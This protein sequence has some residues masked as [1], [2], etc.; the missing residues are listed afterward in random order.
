MDRHFVSAR[1]STMKRSAL[2][3][4]LFLLV[5][6]LTLSAQTKLPPKPVDYGQWESLASVGANGGF[7][8]DGRWLVYGINRSNRNNEI[9]LVKPA[10]GTV[11]TVAFGTQPVF[12][13]DS[14]WLACSVGMSEADSKK[15]RDDK[16]PVQNKL[17]LVDLA[18]AESTTIDGVESFGLSP[19]GAYL[20]M[21]RYAP[22]SAGAP[23]AAGRPGGSESAAAAP[24]TTLIV[25]RLATGIDTAFGNVAEYA[26]QAGDKGRY[27]AF[28]LSVEGKTGNGVHLYDPASGALR[29]LDS[30]S[31]TYSGLAWRK[32][33]PDLAVFRAKTNEKKDGPTQVLL[34]WTGIGGKEKASI[35]DPTADASFPADRRIVDFQ[36]LSWSKQGDVLFLGIASWEN[37]I[38]P[39]GEKGPGGPPRSG[40]TDVSTVEIW[41]A[42]DVFVMPFQKIQAE[43]FR[44]RNMLAAH[45]LGSGKLVALGRDPVNESLTPIPGGKTAYAAEWSKYAFNRTIGRPDA[46]LYL[47]DVLTGDRKKVREALDD[48]DVQASPG[49]KYLLFIQENH[50]WTV[51]TATGKV[52]NIT[53]SIPTSFINLESDQT[54]PDKPAFGTA[55]WAKDDAAVLL[56][57]K[58]DLWL[59]APDGSGG[60]KLTDGASEQVRHRLFR[61]DSAGGGRRGYGR[62]A[63]P[64]EALDLSKPL[65]LSLYGEW[66]KKSGY[67]RLAPGGGIERL[68]FVDRTVGGLEKA[69]NAEVY[70]YTLQDYDLSPNVFVAGPDLKDAKKITDTNAF[71]EKFAWGKSELIEY[72]T[73]KGRRLQGA[74]IYPAGYEPVKKYPMIVYTYELV[75]QG[76][77]NYVVP[78]ERSYYN[79]AVFSSNGYFVLLPDI[80]FRERQPGWSVVECVL[81]G[82]KKALER[83]AIDPKKVGIV[84]HSMGGF[85]SAFV[86]TR[87]DGV[88]AAAVAGAP[89]IDMVSYYSDHHWGEGIAETDHIETGQERMVVPL[90]EDLQ[91]YI[92]NSPYYGTHRMTVPL[93]LE[94][95]DQD[96][97]VAW[98]QSIELYNVARRA[99]KNVVMLTY[100]GEDHGLRQEKNQV[101]YQRRIL[102]WFGHYLKGEP[103]Q[104]WITEGQSYLERQAEIKKEKAGK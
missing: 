64:P 74:L 20:A 12:S 104:P 49:G 88:F 76:L 50:Y 103:A 34:A 58:Y 39:A 55:G 28:I 99:G 32:D 71:Q 22:A 10:D 33:A 21:K 70:A 41:H 68:I 44:R 101:D 60:K 85:N 14:K 6:A 73:D 3:P 1:R 16:K 78:S 37:Q 30:S 66:T 63:E 83:D 65:Y 90:Y 95:G 93:L 62:P 67:A 7:S 31:S 100:M 15:L 26:W 72:T 89:I 5:F 27:L 40:S 75:S 57:D 84:G 98:H 13:S 43:S 92:D 24:G 82:V 19:D 54:S 9:R 42:K 8:P 23:P 47:V 102:A 11:K 80:V 87:V 77:H 53:A 17:A 46:D 35:Y 94:A 4:A 69:K 38:A 91:A 79:L 86:A 48:S 29:V 61:L 45:H 36:R 51:D 96:G 81:A 52:V 97:I 59:V 18:K 25:R 56:Y 2:A